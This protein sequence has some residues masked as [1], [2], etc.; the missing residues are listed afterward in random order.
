MKTYS[1]DTPLNYS[2]LLLPMVLPKNLDVVTLLTAG[3]T[4]AYQN[5]CY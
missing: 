3:G 5:E 1:H 4:L 2:K